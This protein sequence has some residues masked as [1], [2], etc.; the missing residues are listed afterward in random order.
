KALHDKGMFNGAVG[1]KKEGKL[2]LKKGYGTANFSMETPFLAETAMEVASVS[3]QFTA[4]AILLLEQEKKLSLEDHLQKYLGDD[5][6]YAN[7]TIKHILTHTS[8][9]PDYESHFRKTWDTT[10][11]AT[12]S[13]IVR[14]FKLDK[15]QLISQPGTK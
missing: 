15:P 10:K 7:I 4:F 1:V 11:I 3:K 9:L 12:N 6:P 8:G 14:F 5:F 13:D 2:I